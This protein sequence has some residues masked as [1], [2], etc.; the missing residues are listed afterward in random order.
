MN[1]SYIVG[2]LWD[3]ISEDYL[4]KI[5]TEETIRRLKSAPETV[6][7]EPA[8]RMIRS[9]LGET[10]GKKICILGSGDNLAGIALAKLGAEVTAVD[11]SRKQL[12]GS[13]KLAEKLEIKRI[14]YI[15]SD[16]MSPSF[17]KGRRYD[18][19]LTTNGTLNFISD[20]GAL[21]RNIK[22]LM[23]PEGYYML[24]DTHPFI[25]PFAGYLD[26][27]EIKKP[28][29]RVGPF[30][31]VLAYHWRMQD[32]VNAFGEQ[33]IFL[34]ECQ[35]FA[36][37]EGFFWEELVGKELDDSVYDWHQNPLAALPQYLL[38]IGKH[39]GEKM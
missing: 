16:I 37:P 1:N 32:Y 2:Q 34:C 29:D 23:K 10:G 35:E 27:L 6:F 5:Y 31:Q 20:L 33:G 11:L 30:T 13:R 12:D 7:P 38:M 28:Y 9:C 17:L 19:V 21:F 22:R 26:R 3:E 15:Q 14:E 4:E 8:L 39:A 24:F 36:A 18:L 25:R